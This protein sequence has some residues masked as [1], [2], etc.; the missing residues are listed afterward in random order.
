MRYIFLVL[1]VLILGTSCA[2]KNVELVRVA[3]VHVDEFSSDNV[4]VTASLVLK[5]PNDFEIKIKDSDLDLY[6]N[7]YKVARADIRKMIKIPK[8]TV[9][10][11]DLVFDSSLE[12][13]GGGV[14]RSLVSVIAR[15]IVKIGIKGSVNA[16]AYK[17]TEK[18][19]VDVEGDVKV[20][21][22]DFFNF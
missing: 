15:G 20:D 16:T 9:M 18:V 11:H 19:P 2:Y 13:V 14:L 22:G 5:N 12:D 4:Q 7:D 17:M 21:V 6:V 8:N 1:G 3:S 10:T